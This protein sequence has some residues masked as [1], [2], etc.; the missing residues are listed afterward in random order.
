MTSKIESDEGF[1]TFDLGDFKHRP[2]VAALDYDHTL[3]VPK[4]G[5]FSKSIDDWKWIRTNVPEIVK[6]YY[7]DGFCVVIFTNQSKKFKVDQIKKVL[8]LLK[9]PIRVYIGVSTKYKKPG[10][11]KSFKWQILECIV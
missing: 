10:P 2:K 9:I 7:K 6:Q 4:K 3:V 1:I 11:D 5:T 8:S